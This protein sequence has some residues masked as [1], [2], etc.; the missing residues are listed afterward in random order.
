MQNMPKCKKT[1]MHKYR[2]MAKCLSLKIFKK[3]PNVQHAKLRD[4]QIINFPNCQHVK[5]NKCQNYKNGRKWTQIDNLKMTQMRTCTIA[6]NALCPKWQHFKNAKRPNYKNA[7][8]AGILKMLKMH[9]YQ[10]C[11][12]S[13]NTKIRKCKQMLKR[14][15]A[16]MPR[17]RKINRANF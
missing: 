7:Q 5:N 11:W 2:Q 4:G 9:K 10:Q 17:C 1:E 14:Q 16:E 15:N 3:R 8:N 6:K 13:T 12:N